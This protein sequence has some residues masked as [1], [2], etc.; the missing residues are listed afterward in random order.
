MM[1][2]NQLIVACLLLASCNDNKNET[3][4]TAGDS[5]TTTIVKTESPAATGGGCTNLYLF[6]EGTVIEGA[7]YDAGGKQISTQSS[8]VLNVSAEGGT[9]VSE[10]EMK[11]KSQGQDERVFTGKYSCDGNKLYVDL[12]N[13]FGSMDARGATIEGDAIE[14]PINISEGEVLPDASYTMRM[15]QG[16]REMKITSFMKDRK[17]AGKETITTP[18]GTFNC[19]KISANVDAKV[20]MDGMDDKTKQVME[21]MKKAMPKQ[22]FVMY[23]DPAVSIVKVEMFSDGKLT[24]RTEVTSIQNK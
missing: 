7:S 10:V 1:K 2:W 24:S 5:A 8:K 21:A 20:E 22:S 11:S 23:F 19:Y 6:R 3:T 15:K 18:A 12:T 14:F 4:T 13:L 17:V 16:G 9:L